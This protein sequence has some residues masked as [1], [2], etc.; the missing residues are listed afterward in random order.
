MTHMK[1]DFGSYLGALGWLPA[2][3]MDLIVAGCN[4]LIMQAGSNQLINFS[5]EAGGKAHAATIEIQNGT[6]QMAFDVAQRLTA[7]QAV[8]IYVRSDKRYLTPGINGIPREWVTPL[9]LEPP[10]PLAAFDLAKLEKAQQKRKRK[11]QQNRRLEENRSHFN[12]L[13]TDRCQ[14]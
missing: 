10:P 3:P 7:G 2:T 9:W 1:P 5:V 12:Q 13:T 11:A 14:L 6:K 4:P 8:R